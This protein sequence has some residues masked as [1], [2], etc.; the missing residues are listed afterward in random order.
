MVREPERAKLSDRIPA[1]ALCSTQDL[2]GVSGGHKLEEL[3]D[4]AWHPFGLKGAMLAR[5]AR[6]PYVVVSVALGKGE[7][8]LSLCANRTAG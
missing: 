3:D 2:L 8:T 5:F 4:R 6:V 7:S 1:N